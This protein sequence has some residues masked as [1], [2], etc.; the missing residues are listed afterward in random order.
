M[1]LIKPAQFQS[2]QQ[3][4][5]ALL[6]TLVVISVLLAVGI[7]MLD[8]TVKQISLSTTSRDSE[9]SFHAASAGV[10]CAVNTRQQIDPT[11]A[12]PSSKTFTCFESPRGVNETTSYGGR[13]HQYTAQWSWQNG[14]QDLCTQVDMFILDARA[15]SYTHSF[16]DQGLDD[17]SCDDGGVCTVVFSRGFNRACNDLDSLRTVQRELTIVF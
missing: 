15:G 2:L 3:T 10:E 1:K 4:G 13:S 14:D 7:S 16:S 8:V 12:I 5:F 9:I 6:I 11:V 17:Q